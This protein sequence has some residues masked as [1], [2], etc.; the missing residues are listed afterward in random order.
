[1]LPSHYAN[2]GLQLKPTNT[3]KFL[4][5]ANSTSDKTVHVGKLGVPKISI[6]NVSYGVDASL[7][8]ANSE[9]PVML[10]NDVFSEYF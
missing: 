7:F 8:S 6:D 1:M 9:R 4:A 5:L 2:A 10:A 3:S